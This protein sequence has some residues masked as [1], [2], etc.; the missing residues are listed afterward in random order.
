[1]SEPAVLAEPAVRTGAGIA[2][3][4]LAVTIWGAASV[5]VKSIDGIDGV[6][7]SFYRLLFGT[8]L[9][10]AVYLATGARFSRRMLWLCIPGGIA[11]GLDILLFFSALRETSTA[12]ATV[13][14]ALQPILLLPIGIRMFG[15]SVDRRVMAFSFVA[16]AGTAVVVFGGS[17]LPQWSPYGDLLATGALCTWTAYFVAS[18]SARKEL[19]ALQYFTGLTV[20]A[21]VIVTPY[22]FV[23]GADVSPG[24]G[25]DWMAIIAVTVFSGALGH[26][27][28]NWS[29]GRVPLQVMSLLTLLVP[30]VATVGAVL[31]LDEPVD[32]LQWVGMAVV[33]AALAVVAR[34]SARAETA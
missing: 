22:T 9:L 23:S 4:G 34:Q 20:V 30:V 24:D 15:E 3:T 28:L 33:L 26:V 21:F 19:G 6:G 10:S 13:I 31:F 32:G 5:L 29:H 8:V 1:M 11:F 18:K 14:G 12:N 2:A 27:L 16:V 7:I 17:G 25:S